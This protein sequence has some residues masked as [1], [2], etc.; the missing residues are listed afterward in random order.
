[1]VVGR[2]VGRSS[3]TPDLIYSSSL[4]VRILDR[5]VE[6]NHATICSGLASILDAMLQDAA[7]TYVRQITTSYPSID[8]SIRYSNV[9]RSCMGLQSLWEIA[10]FPQPEVGHWLSDIVG[11]VSPSQQQLGFLFSKMQVASTPTGINRASGRF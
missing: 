8:S 11:T 4:Y 9:T 3:Y 6:S 1:M 5:A 2:S 7:V 10:V